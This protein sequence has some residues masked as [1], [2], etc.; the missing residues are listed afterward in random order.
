MRVLKNSAVNL[1]Q[2]LL[3]LICSLLVPAVVSSPRGVVDRPDRRHNQNHPQNLDDA[4]TQKQT[5]AT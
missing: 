3:Y 2:T 1:R 4:E 5:Q